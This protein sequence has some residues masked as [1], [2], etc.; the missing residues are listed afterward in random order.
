MSPGGGGEPRKLKTVY[1]RR[2]FRCGS[3]CG[4]RE[5]SG[6]HIF[7]IQALLVTFTTLKKQFLNKF[8]GIALSH[9]ITMSF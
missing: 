1:R 2:I 3:V 5:V 8:H 7:Q 6:K 9:H 4:D